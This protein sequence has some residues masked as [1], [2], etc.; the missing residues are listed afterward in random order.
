MI[1]NRLSKAFVVA[2][3][4]GSAAMADTVIYPDYSLIGIEGG[5]TTINSDID[6]HNAN[7]SDTASKT[8][9]NIGVKIG[10]ESYNYRIFLTAD[11]YTNP[12]SSYDYMGTY[13]GEL[14]YLLNVSTKVNLYIGVNAGMVNMKFKAPNE[15]SKRLISDP[16]YGADAGL[17]FHASKLIDLELG[18]RLMMLDATNTKNNVTYTFNNFI[19]A[20]ASIIFKY[21]M[22]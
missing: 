8:V 17:N 14:D 5:S 11:Y 12:D 16:Y 6:D 15:T 22:H 3:M 1:K 20:Y 4:L 19:T 9:Q 21:E 13:G 2:A 10:A 7:T 18:A